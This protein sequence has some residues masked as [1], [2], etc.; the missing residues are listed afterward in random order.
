MTRRLLAIKQDGSYA[1]N[2]KQFER[3]F[4]PIPEISESVLKGTF[5]NRLDPKLK[6]KVES[7]NPIGLEEAMREAQAIND[8]IQA[9]KEIKS[10][11]KKSVKGDVKA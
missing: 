7:R 11:G 1:E 6:A 10:G 9:M 8:E 2:R 3:F 4:A 5:I